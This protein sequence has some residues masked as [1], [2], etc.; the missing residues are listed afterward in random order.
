[1]SD[2]RYER[3]AEI[4][5]R[6]YKDFG[7]SFLAEVAAAAPDLSRYIREF[8]FGDIYSRP[9]LEPRQREMIIISSLATIGYA[10]HELKAHIHGAL[11][12]GVTREEIVEI[13]IQVAPYAGFPA[14]IN[15]LHA[16]KEVF[17]EWDKI[18]S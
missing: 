3:G 12:V 6:V 8:A 13:L 1:M 17:S 7:D 2:D 10:A 11:N 16:A 5:A 9:G 15:G 14:A 18:S 4:V